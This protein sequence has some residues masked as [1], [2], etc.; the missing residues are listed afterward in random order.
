M[1]ARANIER[2]ERLAIHVAA[3]V[4]VAPVKRPLLERLPA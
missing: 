1:S 3:P 4:A 2:A